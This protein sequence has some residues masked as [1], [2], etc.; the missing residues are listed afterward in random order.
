MCIRD[1]ATRR[2][3]VGRRS[4]PPYSRGTRPPGRAGSFRFST[5]TAPFGAGCAVAPVLAEWRARLWASRSRVQRCPPLGERF[6]ERLPPARLL[7][8]G[9]WHRPSPVSYTHLTLPTILR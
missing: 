3:R 1:S 8:A 2:D 4:T 9:G 6:A 7:A 5:R